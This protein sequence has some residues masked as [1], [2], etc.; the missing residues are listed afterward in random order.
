MSA[1][2][3]ASGHAVAVNPRYLGGA[4]TADAAAGATVLAIDDCADLDDVN[5]G[6]VS[7]NG[8][9]YTYTDVD[10]DPDNAAGPISTI[11]L[12]SGLV[13]DA[14][15]GDQVIMTDANGGLQRQVIAQVVLDGD[16][17]GDTLDATVN[18]ALAQ[19]LLAGVRPGVAEAV[20]LQWDED[21]NLSIVDVLGAPA[22]IDQRGKVN[23][24]LSGSGPWSGSVTVAFAT[25][26]AAPPAI[27]LTPITTN[28]NAVS[29]SVD[30]GTWDENGFTINLTRTDANVTTGVMWTAGAMTQ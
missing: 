28:P 29:P 12:S 2:R 20:K 17:P 25:P 6:S 24:A 18:D 15:V 11:T 10:D 13:A 9:G 26:F 22:S 8:V 16:D 7:I 27:T 30:S 5:G 19:R 14:D 21:D 1:L 4:L 23:V 3:T